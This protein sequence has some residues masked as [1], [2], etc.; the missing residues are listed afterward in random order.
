MGSLSWWQWSSGEEF[1]EPN[2]PID[3]NDFDMPGWPHAENVGP[4]FGGGSHTY[5]EFDRTIGESVDKTINWDSSGV[6]PETECPRCS[7][8]KRS[9]RQVGYGD[10]TSFYCA[11][12]KCVKRPGRPVATKNKGCENVA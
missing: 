8:K 9:W 2:P 11:E 12:Y 7:K 3:D 4:C 10:G 1:L 5:S 6:A